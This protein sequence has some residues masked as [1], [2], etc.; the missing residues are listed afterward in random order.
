M[1]EKGSTPLPSKAWGAIAILLVLLNA[2]FA[3]AR[4][5]DAVVAGRGEPPTF[6]LLLPMWIQPESRW[7]ELA[8]LLAAPALSMLLPLVIMIPGVAAFLWRGG[9]LQ[10][11]IWPVA[12]LAAGVACLAVNAACA[13]I[14]EL[15]GGTLYTL[16]CPGKY[17]VIPCIA[18]AAGIIGMSLRG[19]T[20]RPRGW[21]LVMLLVGALCI[22]MNAVTTYIISRAM[23]SM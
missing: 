14:P 3:V 23:P 5:R 6:S 13:H 2:G 18:I 20:E 15:A 9:P 17:M 22:I 11:R 10:S 16:T 1:S 19:A 8:V 12:L 4:A 7:A 21:S